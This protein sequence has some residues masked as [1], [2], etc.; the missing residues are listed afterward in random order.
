MKSSSSHPGLRPGPLFPALLALVLLPAAA[1]AAPPSSPASPAKPKLLVLLVVDQMRHDYPEWYG[2]HWK[3]GLRRLLDKGAWMTQA[4]YPYLNTVTCPGHATVGTGAYPRTHGMILNSWYDRERKRVIECTD[5]PAAPLVGYAEARFSGGD[6]GRNLMAPTLGDE[7]Q[8]QLTPRSRV[9]AFSVKARSTIN[10]SAHKPDVGVWFESGTWVTSS[11]FASGRTP[12]VEKFL[13]ANP[14]VVSADKPWN[15]LLPEA[16]YKFTDDGLG[17]K[18]PTGWTNTFP[19]PIKREG[20]TSPLGRWTSTPGVDEYL[21]KLAEAAVAEM[22]LGQQASTDL[23]SIGFSMTDLVGHSFG[24]RSHEVQ[25]TLARLDLAVG[26]LLERLDKDVGPDN[27]AVGLTAD[28]GVAVIPEQLKADGKDAGRIDQRAVLR[29]ADA[30]VAA[31][32]GP[33]PGPYAIEVQ[34]ND[35]YLAPGMAARLAA[36]KGAMGRVLAALRQVPGV[37][38]ALDTAGLESRALPSDPI[39]RAAALSFYP[40]RSGDLMIVPRKD[41]IAGSIGTNHGSTNDYD[42]RVPVLFYGAGI[43]PGKYD[44]A[45]S[46]A[47]VAPTLAR[48]AGVKMAKAEGVALEDVIAAA[49]EAPARQ[50]RKPKKRK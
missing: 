29:A 15:R 22:K 18:A 7:M 3:G 46:P 43:K 14:I 9:V 2:H 47:D 13:A 45:A 4:R 25:D 6:S 44:R 5:D 30:A 19:H 42:Q 38:Q 32:L 33:E 17:E 48:L 26:A 8:Q 37:D 35:I 23:L 36:K 41:W 12:W 27:Y 1:L 11:A 50:A 21:G 20:S 39:R 16:A 40:G 31:E 34:S 49:P 24:P 28:H 10:I